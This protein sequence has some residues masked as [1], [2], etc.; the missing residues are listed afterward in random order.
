MN[1]IFCE[2]EIMEI[3]P[4]L[5]QCKHCKLIIQYRDKDNQIVCK[6]RLSD[7]D[8]NPM[9]SI[10]IKSVTTEKIEHQNQSVS[11]TTTDRCSQAQID[12][13]LDICQGCEYY[14]DNSC[15]QCGCILNRDEVFSNKLYWPDQSCPIGRWGPVDSAEE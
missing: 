13:R 15:L 6:Q 12:A 7:T 1:N 4:L 2:Y 9:S 3:N 5:L 8:R 14:K 11:N 10:K